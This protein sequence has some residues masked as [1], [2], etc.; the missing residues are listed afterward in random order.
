M[1][2]ITGNDY[3][4]KIIGILS[5]QSPLKCAVAFWGQAIVE[6]L[7]NNEKEV[8]IICNLNSGACNPHVIEELK[9]EDNITIKTHSNLHAK[10]YLTKDSALVGS[11]NAS[12]NGL[13]LENGELKG[14]LEAGILLEDTSLLKEIDTWFND[15]W[16]EAKNIASTDLKKAKEL[17]QKRRLNRPTKTKESLLEV[18]RK[19]PQEIKDRNI[20]LILYREEGSKEAEK[21]FDDKK[22]SFV[23]EEDLEKLTYY[24]DWEELPED[25]YLVDFDCK[26]TKHIQ[27]TGYYHTPEKHMLMYFKRKNG[28]R[29]KLHLCYKEKNIFG[30]TFPP[31][32]QKL[33][34]T[35]VVEL[36]KHFGIGEDDGGFCS[37][38]DA[39]KVL[40]SD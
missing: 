6:V 17:W 36:R 9:E 29:G 32:E 8:Q 10:V 20:Y 30:W 3:S 15:L 37:L 7:K 40:F 39:R 1:R 24:E 16:K 21:T 34:K 28:T 26:S 27:F 31:D 35:K 23:E 11:A 5:L 4:Q 2:F 12:A 13:N 38:Y 18:L 25:A 19:N 33:I 14:W 22:S